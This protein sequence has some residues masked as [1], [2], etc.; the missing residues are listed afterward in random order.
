LTKIVLATLWATFSKT[1]LVTLAVAAAAAAEAE[2]SLTT[3][4]S[5]GQC[6]A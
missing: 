3:P 5:S 6:Y 1:H 4:L 2:A